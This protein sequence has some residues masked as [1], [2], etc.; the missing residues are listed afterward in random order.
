MRSLK[1]IG[2]ALVVV[3]AGLSIGDGQ[4]KVE[5]TIFGGLVPPH[6][7]DGCPTA[8]EKGLCERLDVKVVGGGPGCRRST[9]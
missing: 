9:G 7:V 4:A 8:V 3:L 6:R 2:L 5:V 1:V